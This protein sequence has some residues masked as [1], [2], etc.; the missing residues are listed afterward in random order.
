MTIVLGNRRGMDVELALR[1][2]YLDEMPKHDGLFS[3]SLPAI[4]APGWTKMIDLGT[5]I[6][7]N[8]ELRF[9]VGAGEPHEDALRIDACV[10][11]LP[12]VFTDWGRERKKVLG[13]LA[14]YLDEDRTITVIPAKVHRD[15]ARRGYAAALDRTA[16]VHQTKISPSALLQNH[17][18]L[19]NHPV[20]DL[21]DLQLVRG[22]PAL[23]GRQRAKNLYTAGSYCPMDLDPTAQH[24]AEARWEYLVWHHALVAIV[25]VCQNLKSI[26]LQ[27]P[28]AAAMPWILGEVPPLPMAR[29]FSA[30]SHSMHRARLPLKPA[31]SHVL[32]P[33][34]SNAEVV[35][36]RQRSRGVMPMK[37][38]FKN[39]A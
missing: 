25:R 26:A 32:P 23:V 9:P 28:T 38:G 30:A 37:R 33:L 21:G 13:G 19:R 24:I 17:A 39:T 27:N 18:I 16:I 36:L 4:A 20:W 14:A 10:R 6:D 31:R 12:D 3:L 5:S 34:K 29:V 2:V 8:H 1:W 7:E 11:R 15:T 35:S 22:K